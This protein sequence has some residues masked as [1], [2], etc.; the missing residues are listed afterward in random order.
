HH[1]RL[2]PRR[3]RP[4]DDMKAGTCAHLAST[5][6]VTPAAEYVCDECVA[7]GARRVHLRT[8]PTCGGTHCC[9]PSPT[10]H[11]SAHARATGRPV[12]ASAEPGER[13]LYCYPDDTNAA[14]P[15]EAGT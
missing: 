10:R 6:T 9:D 8:F 5:A 14:W 3:R 11:A 7:M 1:G 15:E 13:W 12:I 4:P 2:L